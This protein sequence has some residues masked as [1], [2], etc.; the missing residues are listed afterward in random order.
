MTTY[1]TEFPT[2]DLDVE[3]P[4]AWTDES[5]HNDACPS[6]DAGKTGGRSIRVYIDHA[7]KEQRDRENSPRFAAI[8]LGWNRDVLGELVSTDNYL[9]LLAE[10]AKALPFGSESQ[11]ETE[12]LFFAYIEEEVDPQTMRDIEM[13][14]QGATTDERIDF[15]LRATT[16]ERTRV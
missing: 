8:I 1:Q 5:W 11:A 12:N 4:K 10:I 16:N 3:I 2:F 7:I 14:A 6:W 13:Y 9:I 15:A